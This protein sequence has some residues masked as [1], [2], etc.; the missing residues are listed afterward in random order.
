MNSS[1][2]SRNREAAWHRRCRA[3]E[4]VREDA[5]GTAHSGTG[6]SDALIICA[7]GAHALRP[8][9]LH[10]HLLAKPSSTA[11]TC[12]HTMKSRKRTRRMPCPREILY[13]LRKLF[14][15]IRQSRRRTNRIMQGV[16]R[17]CLY[18]IALRS[19]RLSFEAHS[20]RRIHAIAGVDLDPDELP[21]TLKRCHSR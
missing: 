4:P 15:D 21:I 9:A 17:G 14:A 18:P 2:H 12:G 1:W 11:N 10:R 5:G 8:L 20:A 7:S 16:W 13:I 6:K 3:G 19:H